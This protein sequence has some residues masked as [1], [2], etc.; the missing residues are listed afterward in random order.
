MTHDLF[1][2]IQAGDTVSIENTDKSGLHISLICNGGSHLE[3]ELL[4]GQSLGFS[5]GATGA[6]VV[7]HKGNPEG[8]LV[9][10][11]ETAT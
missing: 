1:D 4:P 11:P 10:K 5:A 9:I 3:I 6:K 7:L 2:E 8:L